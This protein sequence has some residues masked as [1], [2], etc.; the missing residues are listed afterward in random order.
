MTAISLW[1]LIALKLALITSI[2]QPNPAKSQEI[3]E[4]P[5]KEKP[6]YNVPLT[7]APSNSKSLRLI[8]GHTSSTLP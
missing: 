8:T 2:F 7:E 4:K 1:K 5:K 6:N 3:A